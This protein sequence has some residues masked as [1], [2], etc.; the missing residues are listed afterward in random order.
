EWR[1]KIYDSYARTIFKRRGGVQRSGSR[2]QRQGPERQLARRVAIVPVQPHHAVVGG[3][4][5]REEV[6]GE[7]GGRTEELGALNE[8]T[9]RLAFDLGLAVAAAPAAQVV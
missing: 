9:D 6:V 5:V 3:E 4:P 8:M 2:R 7:L 1:E